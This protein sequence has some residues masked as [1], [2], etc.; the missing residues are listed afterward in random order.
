MPVFHPRLPQKKKKK[1]FKWLWSLRKEVTWY[2]SRF[3]CLEKHTHTTL[4]LV[5][6][7]LQS[8]SVSSVHFAM[9]TQWHCFPLLS[10]KSTWFSFLFPLCISSPYSRPTRKRGGVLKLQNVPGRTL[11]TQLA[12]NKLLLSLALRQDDDHKAL[13]D[14][15][16][17][18][19]PNNI[20][21]A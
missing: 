7:T 17:Q 14:S 15:Q 10:S 8:L 21:T 9:L 16:M 19:Q 6:S 5:F 12:Q 11:W 2:T 1:D 20:V 13:P 18:R 3:N 4:S